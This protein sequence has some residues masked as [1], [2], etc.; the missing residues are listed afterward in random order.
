MPRASGSGSSR[1]V[2]S[3]RVLASRT[4]VKRDARRDSRCYRAFCRVG[5]VAG[6][7]PAAAALHGDRRSL[8]NVR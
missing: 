1:A 4:I 8:Y 5:A 7:F 2:A 3:E 6:A